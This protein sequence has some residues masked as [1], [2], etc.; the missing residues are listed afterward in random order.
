MFYG[1]K[2]APHQVEIVTDD[3]GGTAVNLWV[4]HQHREDNHLGLDHHLSILI[5]LKIFCETLKKMLIF[6]KP[7]LKRGRRATSFLYSWLTASPWLN[8]TSQPGPA[9]RFQMIIKDDQIRL[10]SHQPPNRV[11][12]AFHWKQFHPVLSTL[13]LDWAPLRITPSMLLGLRS[14]SH[15]AHPLISPCDRRRRRRGGSSSPPWQALPAGKPMCPAP[16]HLE[17]F[18]QQTAHLD[19]L[20]KFG[21]MCPTHHRCGWI[22]HKV[23]DHAWNRKS[24]K[25]HKSW[26]SW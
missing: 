23:L 6:T 18:S 4:K 17:W 19:E 11:F 7:I 25:T 20:K 9:C 13:A 2:P 26:Q 10:T 8:I 12:A 1:E 14:L 5:I 21:K 24:F 3:M 15:V 16:H 22:Q